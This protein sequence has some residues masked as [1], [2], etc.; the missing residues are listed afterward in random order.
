MFD[1]DEF[2]YVDMSARSQPKITAGN[3]KAFPAPGPTA[4][5]ETQ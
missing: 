5:T 2:A 1:F 4:G 3:C